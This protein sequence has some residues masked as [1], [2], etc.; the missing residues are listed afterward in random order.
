VKVLL[1]VL[2]IFATIVVLC[3]VIFGVVGFYVAHKI[4]QAAKN[5]VMTAARLMVMA[6]PDLETVSSNDSTLVIHDRK[7]GKNATWKVDSERKTM[8]IVDGDGK[9]VTMR[10]DP[11]SN[12][13][14]VTDE[15]GKTAT[16]TANQQNGSMEIKTT[17]GDVKFGGAADKAPDWVPSYPGASNTQNTMS[18]ND[19]NQR[20]GTFTF[21]TSD[22]ADKVLSFYGDGLKSAGFKVSTMTTNNDGKLGGF[23]TGQNDADKHTV[24][25]TVT[26]ENDGT[27]VGTTYAEKK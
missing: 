9:S 12:R 10:L 13:L 21:T 2:G 6:N 27:H 4:N 8:V 20:T 22:S 5:P 7:T 19:A 25:V 15:K 26:T 16:I 11:E 23:V 14:V 24:T 17:D 3:I 18:A 1:W